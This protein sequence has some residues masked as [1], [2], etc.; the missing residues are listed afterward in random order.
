M[1]KELK[2]I[3]WIVINFA[4]ERR[5][6][7]NGSVSGQLKGNVHSLNELV[8]HDFTIL[9]PAGDLLGRRARAAPEGRW[10]IAIEG[11]EH[12]REQRLPLHDPAVE[13]PAGHLG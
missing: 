6:Q 5:G 9:L 8:R 7:G 11:D 12:S 1:E 13:T 2:N 4:G 10:V 3:I